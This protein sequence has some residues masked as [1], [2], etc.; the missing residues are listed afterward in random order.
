LSRPVMEELY[1]Y[2]YLFFIS[3]GRPQFEW[4][5][6][7]SSVFVILICSHIASLTVIRINIVPYFKCSVYTKLLPCML[8]MRHEHFL[9]SLSS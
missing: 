7:V 8:L 1:V 5:C 2:L 4:I 6:K 9:R 3:T